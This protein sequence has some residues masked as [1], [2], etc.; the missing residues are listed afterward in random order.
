MVQPN[1]RPHPPS[2]YFPTPTSLQP[3]NPK[4]VPLPRHRL[5]ACDG[6]FLAL[7]PCTAEYVEYEPGTGR[8]LFLACSVWI[9]NL[10]LGR[11]EEILC[12]TVAR[13]VAGKVCL[14]MREGV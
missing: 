13:R 1:G 11:R 4:P 7:Y 12:P 9:G 2:L 8:A 5:R 6:D 14:V 3:H 10:V